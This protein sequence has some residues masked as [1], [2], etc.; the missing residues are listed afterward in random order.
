MLAIALAVTL[1][2]G[3]GHANARP[4]QA[5]QG[6]GNYEFQGQASKGF[7]NYGEPIQAAPGRGDFG[8][9]GF[10]PYAVGWGAYGP[11]PMVPYGWG[12][13]EFG[14]LVQPENVEF[15]NFG[16][17]AGQEECVCP[18]GPA[19]EETPPPPRA[20]VQPRAQNAPAGAGAVV[21]QQGTVKDLD[22]PQGT[23]LQG[24]T[25]PK[26]LIVTPAP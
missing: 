14:D 3:G 24:W 15:T 26:V 8:R 25:N 20:N 9:F 4:S 12:V 19:P 16:P 10:G 17:A 6:F 7:G 2:A 21:V 13:D 22:L 1:A 18:P 5:S 11:Y 23:Q